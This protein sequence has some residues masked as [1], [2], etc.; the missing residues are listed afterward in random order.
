MGVDGLT[1]RGQAVLIAG[2]VIALALLVPL[3]MMVE[4]QTVQTQPAVEPL[5]VQALD[6]L[7][8]A[9][10]HTAANETD[11]SPAAMDQQIRAD[12]A[13][14]GPQQLTHGRVV[15]IT[16]ADA[17][18]AALALRAC[19]VGE[20]RSHRGLIVTE[21]AE[22]ERVVGVVFTTSVLGPSERGHLTTTIWVE[23]TTSG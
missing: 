9:A 15:R 17:E 7:L 1:E 2:A 8:G 18:A 12:V 22:G 11:R 16:Q 5:D 10:V 20:C 14:I 23:P 13:A 6:E 21:S 3:S 4:L 19:P